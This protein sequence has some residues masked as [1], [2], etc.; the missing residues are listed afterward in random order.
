MEAIKNDY[1]QKLT[2]L[3]EYMSLSDM[4]SYFGFKDNKTFDKREQMGLKTVRV[5]EKTKFYRKKDIQE[6]LDG[7]C[8]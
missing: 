2:V 1:N 8:Q 3:K 7:L 5:T 6:F 4:K